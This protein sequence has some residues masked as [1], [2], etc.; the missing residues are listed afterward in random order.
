MELL[1]ILLRILH[2][3]AGV[4]WV[5]AAFTFFLFIE[6]SVKALG[7]NA[8][9]FMEA[10]TVK[11]RFPI[12]ITLAALITILAGSTLYWMA[13]DGLRPERVLSPVGIGFG[14]GGLAAI[15]AFLLGFFLIRP[16][17]DRLGA[18]GKQVGAAG[19]PPSEEERTE[20][21]RIEA[22]L[23]TVGLIDLVLLTVAVVLMASS[24]YLA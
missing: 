15:A 9:P 10:V 11:R 21:E 24:R 3:A 18:I 16:N 23:R 4:F 12:V 17:V 22:T 1:T 19:R 8:G 5:G 6:P 13:S 2:I 20:V 7:P 14:I